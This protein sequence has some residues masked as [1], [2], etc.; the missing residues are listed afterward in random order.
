ME[1]S[2][3][4]QTTFE[5]YK[6]VHGYQHDPQVS[7]FSVLSDLL[8]DLRH[9]AK[10]HDINFDGA[11]VTSEGNFEAERCPYCGEEGRED[12]MLNCPKCAGHGCE[13]CVLAGKCCESHSQNKFR[14]YYQCPCGETWSDESPHQNDDPCPECGSTCSP[15]TS[16]DI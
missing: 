5:Y 1:M 11:L 2:V 4:G 10:E 16:E 3:L 9:F 6:S 8:T 13:D 7:D 12:E 14:N 15:T